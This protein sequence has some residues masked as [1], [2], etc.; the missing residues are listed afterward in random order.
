MYRGKNLGT[1]VT[2]AQYNAIKSGAFEDLFIGD[3]WTI[4]SIIYRIAAF[5]YYLR[6]GDSV[7]TT[8]HVVI[9]PD[10]S[11]YFAQMHNTSSGTYESGPAANTTA[12]GY[13]GSDMYKTNLEKAKN[14]IKKAFS[15]HVLQHRLYLINTVSNSGYP[16]AGA[17]CDSE[18]DL[19]CE[20]MVYGSSIFS[21]MGNGSLIPLNYTAEKSQLP[22]FRY[23]HDLITIRAN[24]WLRD[25]VSDTYFALVGNA[26]NSGYDRASLCL[27]VRPVFCIS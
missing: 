21:P 11:L 19:M 16:V 10:S 25:V 14:I 13:V 3:Y 4:N 7:L 20:Q 8:H 12:G 1:S 6:C 2:D 15:G 9:V 24:Y 18:V 22:L 17:W 23:R 27:G 26:G 5:D